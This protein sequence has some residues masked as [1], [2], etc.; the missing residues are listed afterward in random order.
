MKHI[1]RT[2]VSLGLVLSWCLFFGQI[3]DC[4]CLKCLTT[5]TVIS[6]CYKMKNTRFS[7]YQKLSERVRAKS[8]LDIWICFASLEWMRVCWTGMIRGGSTCL[9]FCSF[10]SFS[11]R[12]FVFLRFF[13]H[14]FAVFRFWKCSMVRGFSWKPVPFFGLKLYFHR[15]FG[16]VDFFHYFFY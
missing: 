6:K 12:L 13:V 1:L 11:A 14:L 5:V 4:Q 2:E 10:C 9:W 3:S 16:F 15:F 7:F 8:F